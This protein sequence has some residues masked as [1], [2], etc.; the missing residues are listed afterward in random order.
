MRK[1]IINFKKINIEREAPHN[2]R[3]PRGV[4]KRVSY[5]QVFIQ[6]TVTTCALGWNI[7]SGLWIPQI[8][9]TLHQQVTVHTITL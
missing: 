9:M 8:L 7:H 3:E 2:V 4:F 6:I 5:V 1:K